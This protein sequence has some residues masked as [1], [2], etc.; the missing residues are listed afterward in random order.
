VYVKVSVT[1][2]HLVVGGACRIAAS[3]A[4]NVH[5]AFK[6]E[7]EAE[8]KALTHNTKSL[9]ILAEARPR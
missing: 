9:Q 5:E 8:T 1:V 2:R 6:P 4:R 7:T 3:K